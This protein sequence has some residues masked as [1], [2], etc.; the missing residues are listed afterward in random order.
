MTVNR[1]FKKL[2]RARMQETGQNFTA[3]RQD[4]LDELAQ[5]P[6]EPSPVAQAELTHRTVVQRFFKD[7]VLTS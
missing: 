5:H 6:S 1:N 2:V 4:L 3:A 7:G